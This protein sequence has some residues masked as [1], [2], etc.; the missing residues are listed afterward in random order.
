MKPLSRS[1]R[2]LSRSFLCL[3]PVAAALAAGA[4][5]LAAPVAGLA[6]VRITGSTLEPGVLHLDAGQ[7]LAFR[8]DSP[9]LARVELDLPRGEG[10][11]CRSGRDPALRGRKFVVAGGDALE[12]QAPEART[13]YRVFR[14]GG[15]GGSL[16]ESAGEL[17]PVAGARR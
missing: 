4:E 8:N 3:V 2:F 15:G 9:A 12:C 5:P 6:T 1:L 14:I 10:I 16:V 17:E 11:V 13:R 7:Q